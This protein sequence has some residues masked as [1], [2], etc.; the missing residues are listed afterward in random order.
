[1]LPPEAEK[2]HMEITRK[3]SGEKRLRIAFDLNRLTS[4]MTEDGIKYQHPGISPEELKDQIS[5]R[6]RK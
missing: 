6:T 1:M 2:K 3:M 5:L 4:R